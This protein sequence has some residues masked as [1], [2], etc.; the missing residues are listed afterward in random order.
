MVLLDGGAA[1][2]PRR[3]EL[4][5]DHPESGASAHAHLL[6]LVG[7]DADAPG[8]DCQVHL[9]AFRAVRAGG[10][11]DL[12]QV[13][14]DR[15]RPVCAQIDG[16]LGRGWVGGRAGVQ[17]G[18][19][20]SDGDR[21]GDHGTLDGIWGKDRA[22]GEQWQG[23][24]GGQPAESGHPSAPP[25]PQRGDHDA[26]RQ[27]KNQAAG[28]DEHRLQDT[29][30]VPRA[31][32]AQD[33][34]T[35]QGQPDHQQAHR[36]AGARDT[37]ARWR[38]GSGSVNGSGRGAGHSLHPLHP[39]HPRH[40]GRARSGSSRSEGRGRGAHGRRASRLRGH[41]ASRRHRRGPGGRPP[42]SRAGL[43]GALG[44]EGRLRAV[45]VVRGACRRLRCV[46]CIGC[47]C[48]FGCIRCICGNCCIRAGPGT[49]G[50][51]RS[52]CRRRSLGPRS[53]LSARSASAVGGSGA[54]CP[55]LS[56]PYGPSELVELA[57]VRLRTVLLPGAQ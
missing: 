24:Q 27:Q 29:D 21:V 34:Q 41:A 37:G 20:Q 52:L 57:G 14:G 38:H 10:T 4:G 15:A 18:I 11:G 55:W 45:R 23:D 46:F 12:T 35:D 6:P 56:V 2:D 22:E 13:E 42:V 1:E 47:T 9:G 54:R 40:S 49:A 53:L 5:F 7:L 48:C 26:A 33:C 3:A 51:L 36:L 39:L 32:H 19:A 30:G 17:V 28:C 25:S 31:H 44:G 43:A 50:G 8:T 16:A